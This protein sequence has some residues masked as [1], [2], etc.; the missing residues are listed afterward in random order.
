MVRSA[1]PARPCLLPAAVVRVL[2]TA[3]LALVGWLLVAVLGAAANAEPLSEPADGQAKAAVERDASEPDASDPATDDCGDRE[4]GEPAEPAQ[5]AEPAEPA[6]QGEPAEPAEQAEQPEPGG[7]AMVCEDGATS[8]ERAEQ[9]RTDAGPTDT[10][11]NGDGQA[12]TAEPG[13]WP[14]AEQPPGR[15]GV[16]LGTLRGAAGTVSRTVDGVGG[17]LG[18]VINPILDLPSMLPEPDLGSVLPGLLPAPRPGTGTGPDVAVPAAPG[19]LAPPP[20]APP[21]AAPDP[22]DTPLSYPLTET[23]QAT[24][25]PAPPA[26][27]PVTETSADNRP[28][29]GGGPPPVAP[30]SISTVPSQ[31]A[32]SSDGGNGPRAEHG[33]LSWAPTLTQLRLLGVSRDGDAGSTGREAALPTT[34]PD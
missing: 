19:L 8:A 13:P 25:A 22:G 3:G 7:R 15:D 24:V 10:E 16:L 20:A 17:T 33:M 21:E 2:V 1:D 28:P 34:S 27:E 4:A 11:A 29:G 18:G 26:A 9:V 6:D 32:S 31:L 5:P 30:V 12:A 14:A 23:M